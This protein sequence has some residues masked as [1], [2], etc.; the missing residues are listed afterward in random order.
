L[1]KFLQEGEETELLWALQEF[2]ERDHVRYF[3]V[4]QFVVHTL[5]DLELLDEDAIFGWE[6]EQR[7][8]TG[9]DD[10]KFLNQC[11][12]FLEWLRTA[13]DDSE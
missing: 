3:A 2:L 13:D 11:E 7:E 9:E 10:R 6:K 5:Y 12:K 4:F 1:Q 8:L